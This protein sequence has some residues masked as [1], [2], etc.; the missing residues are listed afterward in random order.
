MTE[1]FELGPDCRE[2]YFCGEPF[3]ELAALGVPIAGLSSL[4]GHYRVGH[5]IGRHVALITLD[6]RGWASAGGWRRPLGPGML[7]CVPANVPLHLETDQGAAWSTAWAHLEPRRWRRFPGAAGVREGVVAEPFAPLLQLLDGERERDDE[8]GSALKR[9]LG[10]AFVLWLRRVLHADADSSAARQRA[11]LQAIFD[12]VRASPGEDWSGERL[13]GLAGC[14]RSQLHRRCVEIF[15]RSPAAH[16]T[17]LRMQEAAYWLMATSV[18]LKVVADRLGYAS[19]YHF[20]AAFKR[21]AGVAPALYREGRRMEP[22]ARGAALK[23][24]IPAA[25]DRR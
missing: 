1:V 21:S 14:S 15:G 24:A 17:T 4:R 13:A 23:R 12:R 11:A 10:E 3:R 25:P 19:P 16:V 2:I 7:L 8:V 22:A 6:G 18:P 9:V 20:S 5:C